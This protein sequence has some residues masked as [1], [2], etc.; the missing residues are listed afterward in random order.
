[1]LHHVLDALATH[2]RD[3]TAIMIAQSSDCQVPC[4]PVPARMGIG[5]P[6]PS[7]AGFHWDE[8]SRS[9]NLLV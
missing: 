2:T 4:P 5:P 3:D 9:R 8:L 7:R 6:L 1:M